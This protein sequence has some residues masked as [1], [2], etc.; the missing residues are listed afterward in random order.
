MPTFQAPLGVIASR[1]RAAARAHS[2][3]PRGAVP[4]YVKAAEKSFVPACLMVIC[5]SSV[6]VS[7]RSLWISAM[8]FRLHRRE[9]IRNVMNNVICMNRESQ[10]AQIQT[11]RLHIAKNLF[12]CMRAF[13]DGANESHD[14]IAECVSTVTRERSERERL[15]VARRR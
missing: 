7:R 1:S 10:M 9:S 12:A 15:F 5:V 6:F 3:A 11:R 8:R 2:S 4:I 13:H 14:E